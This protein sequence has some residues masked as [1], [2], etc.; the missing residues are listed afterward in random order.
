MI[1][2]FFRQILHLPLGFLADVR[3][4]FFTRI[5]SIFFKHCGDIGFS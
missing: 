4:V 3:R 2:I 5:I 1:P